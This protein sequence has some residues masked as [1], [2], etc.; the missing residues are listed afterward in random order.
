[1]KT[2]LTIRPEETAVYALGGLVKSERTLT[3]LNLA[4]KLSSLMLVLNPED[5]L[6]GVDYV[7]PD[8]TY[9]QRK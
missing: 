6:L 3:V 7:I 5:D 9:L 4:M 1:M 8:Y 2:D